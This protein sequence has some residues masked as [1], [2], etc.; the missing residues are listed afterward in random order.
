[1]SA[2]VIKKIAGH[3]FVPSIGVLASVHPFV[4]VFGAGVVLVGQSYSSGGGAGGAKWHVCWWHS[5][6]VAHVVACVL[7]VLALAWM[8]VFCEL[9]MRG[10]RAG[11]P[12]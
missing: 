3:I 10:R 9:F 12:C 2:I 8:V 5:R 11:V 6:C 4:V 1:M 7:V